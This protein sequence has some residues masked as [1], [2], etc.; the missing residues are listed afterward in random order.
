MQK[1]GEKKERNEL[2]IKPFFI[3]GLSC[4]LNAIMTVVIW[5]RGEYKRCFGNSWGFRYE[6]DKGEILGKRISA[7]IDKVTANLHE[8]Y[9]IDFY[10]HPEVAKED[11]IEQIQKQIRA[12]M[13]VVVFC[14]TYY[15]DWQPDYQ[16]QHSDHACL[17]TGFNEQGFICVDS[18]PIRERG[19]FPYSS[20]LMGSRNFVTFDF[21]P[22]DES[23]VD[24]RVLLQNTLNKLN[25]GNDKS[26][27]KQMRA[28]AQ[29]FLAVDM[30]KELEAAST[31][32]AVPL[33]K[34]IEKIYGGRVQFLELLELLKE[35]NA[36]IDTEILIDRFNT[37]IVKWSMIRT[38][39]MR[40]ADDKSPQLAQRISQKIYD[41]ADFEEETARIIQD[42]LDLE[43]DGGAKQPIEAKAGHK[44]EQIRFIDLT[45]Y[46]NE[47][48][49]YFAMQEE[50]EVDTLIPVDSIWNVGEMQFYFPKAEGERPNSI[51]GQE[52]G[53]CIDMGGGCYSSLQ[54]LIYGTW[55]D[56]VEDIQVIYKGREKQII[57]MGFTDWS[58]EPHFGEAVAWEGRYINKRKREDV[59]HGRIYGVSYGVDPE[60]PIE[61]LVW[62][63][64]EFVHVFALSGVCAD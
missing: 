17:I 11:R 57:E 7:E 15:L 47:Y 36:A 46:Y 2:S 38:F 41:V 22:Y 18:I 6:P 55:Q 56:S 44:K 34:N 42:M 5:K 24:C 9:G 33:H 61:K 58:R 29:D 1:E 49:H 40:L 52:G 27:F 50:Y 8:Y 48:S 53:S 16:K 23:G 20:F 35:Q 45:E 43:K 39:I 59:I 30:E 12:G 4:F 60:Y 32:W 28:F 63:E 64:N 13:P 37:L 51:A 25:F 21:L 14:D 26:C 62:P 19:Y 10:Y 31:R 3:A 54:F